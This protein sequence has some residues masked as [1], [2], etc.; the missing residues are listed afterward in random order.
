MRTDIAAGR[1]T[2]IDYMNGAVAR[3]G[4]RYGIQTPYCKMM[5]ELIHI[6]EER[7]K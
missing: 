2:E 1:L 6:L 4:E 3:L 7:D 5:T